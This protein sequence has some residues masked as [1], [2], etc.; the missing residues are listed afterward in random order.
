MTTSASYRDTIDQCHL[1]ILDTLNSL[2]NDLTFNISRALDSEINNTTNHKSVNIVDGI[3]DM[4]GRKVTLEYAPSGM[5]LVVRDGEV[6][7]KVW[8]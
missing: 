7:S 5:Y 3:Y 1:L 4:T 6:I 2:G 8:K